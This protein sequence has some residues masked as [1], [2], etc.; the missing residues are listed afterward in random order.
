MDSFERV[1]WLI[2]I[3]AIIIWMLMEYFIEDDGG[4]RDLEDGE[5]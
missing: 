3:V 2:V 1:F 4:P 5:L